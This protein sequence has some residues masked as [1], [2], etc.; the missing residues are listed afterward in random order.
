MGCKDGNQDDLD[1]TELIVVPSIAG[2]RYLLFG[3]D[4]SLENH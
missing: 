1:R 3:G 4:F 2:Y